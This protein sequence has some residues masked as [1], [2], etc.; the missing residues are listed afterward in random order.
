MKKM[1]E[2]CDTIWSVRQS[3]TCRILFD[4]SIVYM[5]DIVFLVIVITYD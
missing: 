2:I 1:C 5:E 3:I 4:Y